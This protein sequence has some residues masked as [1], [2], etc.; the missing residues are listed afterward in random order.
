MITL[1]KIRFVRRKNS[2]NSQQ[3]FDTLLDLGID[4]RKFP[5]VISHLPPG[6]TI[7]PLLGL[8]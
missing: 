2:V 4:A 1:L 7:P 6:L 3:K 5:S 8:P